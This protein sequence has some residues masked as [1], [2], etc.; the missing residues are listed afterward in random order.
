MKVASGKLERKC[1]SCATWTT[2]TK[3][4]IADHCS[5]CGAEFGKLVVGF[6]VTPR[7]GGRPR[8]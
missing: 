7:A 3:G 4:E 5:K 6:D 2:F 1:R 8:Q